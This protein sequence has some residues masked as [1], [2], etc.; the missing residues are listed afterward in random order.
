MPLLPL[1][2][3]PQVVTA[4]KKK[5]AIAFEPALAELEQLVVRMER[6]DMSLED[7]LQTFER[8]IALARDCQNALRDA[9]QKI[10]LLSRSDGTEQLAPATGSLAPDP[11]TP[12]DDD[13]L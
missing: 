3:A 12:D 11:D 9:E 10:Q 8:G 13:E 2:T 5:S 1:L 7:A 6:G 4:S